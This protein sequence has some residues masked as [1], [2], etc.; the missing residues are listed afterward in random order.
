LATRS[1]ALPTIPGTFSDFRLLVMELSRPALGLIDQFDPKETAT[2]LVQ[3]FRFRRKRN[4]L[5]G[6]AST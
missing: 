6:S 4:N 1:Q 2:K 3:L 5:H